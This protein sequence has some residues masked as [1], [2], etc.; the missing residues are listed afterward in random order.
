M[1]LADGMRTE[2]AWRVWWG[3]RT[4]ARPCA[5]SAGTTTSRSLSSPC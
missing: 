5:E 1:L 4:D 3:S 2:E